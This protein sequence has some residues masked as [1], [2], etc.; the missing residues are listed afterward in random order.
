MST[1][2]YATGPEVTPAPVS[3]YRRFT[4]SR[5]GAVVHAV[6][7][8]VVGPALT[9]GLILGL[10]ASLLGGMPV[11]LVFV[12]IAPILIFWLLDVVLYRGKGSL[13]RGAI[14]GAV[15]IVGAIILLALARG[16][17]DDSA[18]L[19]IGGPIVGI[20]AVGVTR[21][22]GLFP[23]RRPLAGSVPPTAVG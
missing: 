6:V 20:I 9:L 23:P 14:A 5:P 17:G 15:M 1:P 18:K 21:L 2:V 4:T 10:L 16:D 8:G 13:G 11:L 12:P 3:A 7:G 19:Y 22:R